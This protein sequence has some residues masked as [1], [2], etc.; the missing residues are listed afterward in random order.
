MTGVQTCALPICY[1]LDERFDLEFFEDYKNKHCII[2]GPRNSSQFPVWMTQVEAQYMSRLWSWPADLTSEIIRFY[3]AA[4]DYMYQRLTSGG[5]VDIEHCL[6]KFLDP[7][8]IINKNP[9]GI[10]GQ[11]APNGIP[12]KD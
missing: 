8:K 7:K 5:Y 11:L 2:I 6:Y 4:L 3:D 12:I 1:V 9:L 10:S